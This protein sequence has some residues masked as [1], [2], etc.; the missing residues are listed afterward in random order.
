MRV[1]VTGATGFIG[2]AIVRELLD[3]GH[4]VT[5]LARSDRSAKS[6]IAAGAQVVRGNIEDLAALSRGAAESDGA[7]H[8]AFYHALGHMPL[9]TR[10]RVL[11]GG[12][13]G[14]IVSRFFAAAVGADRRAIETLG[15]ALESRGG[16]LLASFGTLS[17]K[18]G[19]LATEDDAPDPESPGAARGETEGTI[20]DLASRGVRAM[21]IRLS[22]LVHG[23]GDRAGLAPML[24]KTARKK[25]SSAYVGDGLNRWPSVHRL[26]AARLF[27]L[28]LERGSAG[29][30]YHA[31]A[32]EGLPF[33]KIAEAIARR[34]EVPA[35]S[36]PLAEA[37]RRFSF[38][39]LFVPVDNPTSSGLTHER[40]GWTPS[41]P[42]L[43]SDLDQ[44]GYFAR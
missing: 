27:R 24:F 5:G 17:L 7:I 8:T 1:F 35:V 40:L 25:G 22:P 43:F 38:L 34:A 14:G 3:A 30:S 12:G 19:Q 2:S 31:V 18:A 28:A 6:L 26:D 44:P 39:S 41:E 10:L 29:A 4:Q 20:R 13:P 16:P 36:I 23:V 37:S 33:R 42:D 11:L 15:Q 9:A 32:E 21:A